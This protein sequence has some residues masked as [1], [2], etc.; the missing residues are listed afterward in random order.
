MTENYKYSCSDAR[1]PTT[2][3]K[4]FESNGKIQ[5]STVEIP[6][7]TNGIILTFKGKGTYINDLTPTEFM[8]LLR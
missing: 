7:L 4:L 3:Q 1:V 8:M 5:P 2:F 6:L